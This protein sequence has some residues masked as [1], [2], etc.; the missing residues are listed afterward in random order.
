M[1]DRLRR[2]T[3]SAEIKRTVFAEIKCR[4]IEG[5]LFLI[6]SVIQKRS[7]AQFQ[8]LQPRRNIYQRH[9]T[10]TVDTRHRA[11]RSSTVAVKQ[12]AH[13]LS[14]VRQYDSLYLFNDSFTTVDDSA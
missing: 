10:L 3:L 6:L 5:K 7:T 2:L 14:P 13:K 11:H 1:G 9:A 8:Y 4:L 12:S